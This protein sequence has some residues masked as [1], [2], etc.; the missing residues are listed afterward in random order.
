[1]LLSAADTEPDASFIANRKLFQPEGC[2]GTWVWQGGEVCVCV[3]KG[4]GGLPQMS[5]PQSQPST[6]QHQSATDWP[7]TSTL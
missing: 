6:P 2:C 3:S 7:L 5:G 4:R 1:M